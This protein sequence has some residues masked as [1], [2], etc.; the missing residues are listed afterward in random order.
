MRSAM[1]ST[2]LLNLIGPQGGLSLYI[3]FMCPENSF[4]GEQFHVFF[5]FL[6]FSTHLFKSA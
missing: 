2:G 5:F 3:S 4:R 1:L 6:S